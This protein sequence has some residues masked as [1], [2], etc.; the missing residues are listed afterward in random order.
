MTEQHQHRCTAAMR[1]PQ[2]V[3]LAQAQVFAI[4][5]GRRQASADQLLATRVIRGH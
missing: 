1:G 4:E 2:I 5:A 3:D